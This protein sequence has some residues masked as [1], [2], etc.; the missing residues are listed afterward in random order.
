MNRHHYQVVAVLLFGGKIMPI[1]R[2]TDML[3][4]INEYVHNPI[5]REILRLRFCDGC[6]YEKIAEICNYSTQHVKYICKTFKP[7][8]ISH[9]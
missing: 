2:N 3:N 6:T 5:Y 9:L 1:Y 8:L 4:A 7:V